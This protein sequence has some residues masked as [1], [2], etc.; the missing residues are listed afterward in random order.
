[1]EGREE[2]KGVK[3]KG[4][5]GK[6]GLGD[7]GGGMTSDTLSLGSIPSNKKIKKSLV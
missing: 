3:G 4:E 1:M 6:K 5:K 2:G 7:M